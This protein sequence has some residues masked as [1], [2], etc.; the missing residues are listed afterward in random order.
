M[1]TSCLYAFLFTQHV[2][3]TVKPAISYLNGVSSRLER[4]ALT[5]EMPMAFCS[6]TV[7]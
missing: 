2:V 6:S 1:S 7:G 4:S 3:S 5:V